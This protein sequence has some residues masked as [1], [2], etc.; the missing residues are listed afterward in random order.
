[1]AREDQAIMAAPGRRSTTGPRLALRRRDAAESDTALLGMAEKRLPDHVASPTKDGFTTPTAGGAQPVTHAD[2]L[3][4][5]RVAGRDHPRR[6][7]HA[8]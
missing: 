6:V 5:R 2:F 1:M 3:I 8:R 7:A 4:P